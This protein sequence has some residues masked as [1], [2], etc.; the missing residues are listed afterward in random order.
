MC[1]F[2]IYIQ[3]AVSFMFMYYPII[4]KWFYDDYCIKYK[5]T[6]LF[7]YLESIDIYS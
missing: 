3:F 4:E 6:T 2:N 7:T 1:F 5:T